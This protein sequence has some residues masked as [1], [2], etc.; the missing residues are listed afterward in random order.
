MRRGTHPN[1]RKAGSRNF[2]IGRLKG[3]AKQVELNF[4]DPGSAEFLAPRERDLLATAMRN[5]H[6]L[7]ILINIRLQEEKRNGTSRD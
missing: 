7:N 5:L 3:L 6:K 2:Y 4:A 1:S